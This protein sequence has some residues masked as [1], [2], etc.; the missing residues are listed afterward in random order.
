MDKD[1]R[2]QR[3][4]ND[5]LYRWAH[6]RPDQATQLAERKRHQIA[7]QASLASWRLFGQRFYSAGILFVWRMVRRCRVGGVLGPR[8]WLRRRHD[9]RW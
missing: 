6:H 9:V 2:D 5:L 8:L 4:A 3:A 7:L 1:P